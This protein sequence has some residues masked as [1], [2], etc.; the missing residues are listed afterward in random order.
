MV[1]TKKVNIL[2]PFLIPSSG[3]ASN[4]P[5]QPHKHGS[6]TD[7]PGGGGSPVEAM[8]LQLDYWTN[9][10]SS[11]PQGS[12]VDQESTVSKADS[13]SSK[14]QQKLALSVSSGGGG[15]GNKEG[16]AEDN[17]SSFTSTKCSIKSSVWSMQLQ[18]LPSS[19]GRE[20]VKIAIISYQK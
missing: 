14:L 13:N 20:N 2:S 12:S 4:S 8:D 9:H 6:S 19:H 1:S 7:S 15:S 11:N 5:H 17:N 18:R 10:D 16:Q 3:S